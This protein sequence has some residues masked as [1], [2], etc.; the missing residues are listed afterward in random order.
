MKKKIFAFLLALVLPLAG[1]A[2]LTGSDQPAGY[3]QVSAQEAMD[4]MAGQENYL[5]LDVRT[6]AEYD[7]GHIPGAI[8]L[9]N[10]D[11]GREDPPQLPLKDQLILVYCRSGNRSKQA[12]DKLAALGY[13]N[14]V[15]FGG[16]NT[17]PGDIIQD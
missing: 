4:M 9:P 5:I 11:I 15:E 17:W 7:G 1:C 12:S 14:V 3:R 16:I 8:S 6:Q 2:A 10:E 13:T